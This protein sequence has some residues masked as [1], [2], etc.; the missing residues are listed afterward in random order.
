L[1]DESGDDESDVR[2]DEARYRGGTESPVA[3][4]PNGNCNGEAGA[5]SP[6]PAGVAIA[7][8]GEPKP[9]AYDVPEH[10]GEKLPTF[11]YVPGIGLVPES[12]PTTPEKPSGPPAHVR[13]SS[14]DDAKDAA[15]DGEE[16]PVIMSINGSTEVHLVREDGVPVAGD[17]GIADS[18]AV[19]Q[20][21]SAAGSPSLSSVFGVP[22]PKLVAT[23]NVHFEVQLRAGGDR[24][25]PH[26]GYVAPVSNP[27]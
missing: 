5:G 24:P 27:P 9:S 10:D 3:I 16:T 4:A 13:K 21:A 14:E 7:A 23:Q 1:P 8:S 15:E 2:S 17:E 20:Y 26:A 18:A 22:A 12:L 25:R 6:K 11:K 19:S